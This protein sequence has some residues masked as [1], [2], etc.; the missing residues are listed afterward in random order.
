MNYFPIIIGKIRYESKSALIKSSHQ[1][2]LQPRRLRPGEKLEL[3]HHFKVH[4]KPHSSTAMETFPS[5]SRSFQLTLNLS[6]SFCVERMVLGLGAVIH[7]MSLI[8]EGKILNLSW[9]TELKKALDT[10]SEE[11]VNSTFSMVTTS[12][13]HNF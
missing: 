7:T 10:S 11:F 4:A 12:W 2:F 13:R 6:K 3:S 5:Q 8:N 9:S 1:E